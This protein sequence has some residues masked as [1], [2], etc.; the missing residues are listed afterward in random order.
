MKI[1][2]FNESN[3]NEPQI[4]DYVICSDM[5]DDD[6]IREFLNN[7]IGQIVRFREPHDAFGHGYQFLV[8]YDDVP[9]ELNEKE[10]GYDNEL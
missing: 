3:I 5:T 9:H 7:T 1:K 6:E 8:K 2:R 4:G 10:F